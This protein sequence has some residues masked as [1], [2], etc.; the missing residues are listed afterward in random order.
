MS[1]FGGHPNL[2]KLCV[3]GYKHLLKHIIIQ[4]ILNIMEPCFY[5]TLSLHFL[6]YTRFPS[7]VEYS[8]DYCLNSRL[9]TCFS[10]ALWLEWSFHTREDLRLNTSE[11]EFSIHITCSLMLPC[12][13]FMEM[14]LHVKSCR[15][16]CCT[17]S[18]S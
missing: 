9:E 7:A 3:L 5:I 8:N 18:C 17:A 15:L 10:I 11:L 12:T 4:L 2:H 13:F 1:N 16:I 6:V 14:D